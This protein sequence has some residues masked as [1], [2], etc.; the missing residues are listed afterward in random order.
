M[1]PRAVADVQHVYLPRP[2]TNPEEDQVDMRLFPVKQLPDSA[3]TSNDRRS[4]REFFEAQD[5]LPEADIPLSGGQG[6]DGIDLSVESGE[7][8]LGAARDVNAECHGQL[9]TL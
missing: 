7:I 6:F 1:Q 4:L 8:A 9:Q 2:H 3:G 5:G